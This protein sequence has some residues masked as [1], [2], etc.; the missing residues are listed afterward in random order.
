M[1]SLA[2]IAASVIPKRPVPLP[3]TLKAMCIIFKPGPFTPLI[4]PPTK[5]I[6]PLALSK[7]GSFNQKEKM[8][9]VR[10]I[11]VT[12]NKSVGKEIVA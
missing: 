9:S 6:V 2:V 1:P 3:F 7:D 8:E 12:S 11:A 5:L 4:D 10:S